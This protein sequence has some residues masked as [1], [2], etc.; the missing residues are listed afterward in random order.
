MFGELQRT[1]NPLRW[2]AGNPAIHSEICPFSVLA[3]GR[4]G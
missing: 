4:A 1:A 3:H 2:A